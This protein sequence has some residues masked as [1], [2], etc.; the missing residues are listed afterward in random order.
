V[1]KMCTICSYPMNLRKLWPKSW[2]IPVTAPL[3]CVGSPLEVRLMT[4]FEERVLMSIFEGSEAMESVLKLARQVLRISAPT[5]FP[6]NRM[7]SA[8]LL[9]DQSTQT[10]QLYCKEAIIPR[11]HSQHTV[12]GLPP[13]SSSALCCCFGRDALSSCLSCLCK[14]LPEA[15]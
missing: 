12:T 6:I 4:T 13:H 3:R 11:E 5:C 10:H 7:F 15:R 9:R 1:H 8:V 2:S 14:T